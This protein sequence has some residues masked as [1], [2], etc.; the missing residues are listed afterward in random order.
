M[1]GPYVKLFAAARDHPKIVGLS[2]SAFRA[3]V[4]GL[5]YCAEY[6]TDGVLPIVVARQLARLNVRRELYGVGLW[7]QNGDGVLV[8][9]Y[10]D[11]Q[12]SRDE[13]ERIRAQR[14]G[15]GRAGGRSSKR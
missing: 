15:A 10:L 1:S 5:C 6:L 7:E 12:R 14:A 2:D 4:E 9:D 11:Y 3:W 8:H 13:V